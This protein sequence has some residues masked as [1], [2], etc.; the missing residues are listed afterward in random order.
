MPDDLV[1]LCTNNP[2]QHLKIIDTEEDHTQ[3]RWLSVRN[4]PQ[5]AGCFVW[6]GFDYLGETIYANGSTGW[7]YVVCAGSDNAELRDA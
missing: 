7:P 5:L 2:S 3:A 1:A 4:N 6:T